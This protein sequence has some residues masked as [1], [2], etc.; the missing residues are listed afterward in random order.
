VGA[1]IKLNFTSTMDK[2][3]LIEYFSPG[4]GF[5]PIFQI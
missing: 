1:N 3:N 5:R 4:I 2:I